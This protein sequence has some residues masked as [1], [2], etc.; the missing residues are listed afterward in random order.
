MAIRYSGDAEVRIRYNHDGFYYGYVRAPG[1]R[2]RARLSLKEVGLTNKGAREL[3]TS[4]K[5]DLEWTTPESYDEAALVMLQLAE[6]EGGLLPLE[7]SRKAKG[8]I[9]IRRLFQAP[10]PTSPWSRLRK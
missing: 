4:E 7:R 2:A 9:V 3:T 1:R 8:H 5:K 10:C 6:I